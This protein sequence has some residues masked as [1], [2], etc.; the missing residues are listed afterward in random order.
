MRRYNFNKIE[1]IDIDRKILSN[2]EL[3]KLDINDD[4]HILLVDDYKILDIE[5]IIEVEEKELE[6]KIKLTKDI[7]KNF[8]KDVITMITF[9]Q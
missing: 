7:I 9:I 1:S 2:D 8:N 5:K 3:I 4:N 6:D